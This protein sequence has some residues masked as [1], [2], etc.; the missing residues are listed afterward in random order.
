MRKNW[1]NS[2][3]ESAISVIP[4][5]KLISISPSFIRKWPW[6]FCLKRHFFS[7]H[8]GSFSPPLLGKE[9]ADFPVFDSIPP[10]SFLCHGLPAGYYAD[11]EAR[12]QVRMEKE[13]SPTLQL[14][15]NINLFEY[16]PPAKLELV[17]E[18]HFFA[19]K[20]W[21]HPS[22]WLDSKVFDSLI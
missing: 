14:A 15:I 22:S 16:L 1:A 4:W 8:H 9:G 10:T 11:Q 7:S 6:N 13:I 19:S 2:E 18:M 3:S 17:L 5:E 20:F 21:S 12:C